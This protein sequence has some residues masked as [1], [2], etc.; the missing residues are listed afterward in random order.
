MRIEINKHHPILEKVAVIGMYYERE[1]K[2]VGFWVVF[3]SIRI[4]IFKE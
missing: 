2:V 4:K 1:L 3:W